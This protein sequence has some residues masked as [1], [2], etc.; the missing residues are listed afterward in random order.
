MTINIHSL[1]PEIIQ[2]IVE[3]V[4]Q[5]ACYERHTGREFGAN[6]PGGNSRRRRRERERRN[7]TGAG[8]PGEGEGEEGDDDGPPMGPGEALMAM[9]GGML[10]LGGLGGN[11]AG[12]AGANQP[13]QQAAPRPARPAN[14]APQTNLNPQAP[15]FTFGANTQTPAQTNNAAV[16][17]DSESD[18]MPPLECESTHLTSSSPMRILTRI[19]GHSRRRSTC[20]FEFHFYSSSPNFLHRF[21]IDFSSFSGDFELDSSQ[22]SDL[23]SHASARCVSSN[24]S[25]R[26]RSLLPSTAQQPSFLQ[27][28]LNSYGKQ[29]LDYSRFRLDRSIQAEGEARRFRL[30][31]RRHASSRISFCS[32]CIDIEKWSIIVGE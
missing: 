6:L 29:R 31:F 5:I 24:R 17:D 20:N 13:H 21:S 4:E 28:D 18:E 26:F 3:S 22:T 10:G 32:S 14:P 23:H 7:R 11:P 30:G 12:G 25:R 27:F 8:Q 16:P 15:V 1:P 2:L 19:V 9:F